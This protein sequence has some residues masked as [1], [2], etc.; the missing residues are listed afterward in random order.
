MHFC[1]VDRSA[2]YSQNR[3]LIPLDFSSVTISFYIHSTEDE[4]RLRRLVIERLGLDSSELEAEKIVGHFGNEILSIRAHAIG[5]RATVIA[6]RIIEQLSNTARVSTRAEIEKAL[7]EHDSLYIRLDRQ[8]L[9]DPL[10]SISD[11]EPIRI[12]L[13]PRSRFGGRQNMKREY[14]ELIR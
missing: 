2:F 5:A 3:G 11:E 8:S 9:Q 12:K 4:D 13:K 6:A 14:E 1:R 10:L 7:D